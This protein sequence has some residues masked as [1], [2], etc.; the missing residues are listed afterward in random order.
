MASMVQGVALGLLEA[1]LV[2]G[3]RARLQPGSVILNLL[4][5][6]HPA[7]HNHSPLGLKRYHDTGFVGAMI[8][9][10]FGPYI[11]S[12]GDNTPLSV[13][14]YYIQ[15]GCESYYSTIGG[16]LGQI[17]NSLTTGIP[18]THLDVG[19]GVGRLIADSAS[20]GAS[21]GLGIDLFPL[22]LEYA[23]KVVSGTGTINLPVR[24][25]RC[26][27]KII[28]LRGLGYSTVFFGQADAHQLPVV[29]GSFTLVSCCNVLHRVSEPRLVLD[30][31][32]RVT[33]IGGFLLLSNSYDWDKE[34]TEINLWFDDILELH[35]AL[36][37]DANWSLQTRI[38]PVPYVSR[39]Y[40]RKYTLALNE[41]VLLRRES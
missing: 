18:V 36:G 21:L 20:Y 31:L 10:Q 23:Y 1:R 11:R 39:I 25:T 5:S 8:E 3:Y 38:D 22:P 30:E 13:S 2:S 27:E 40:D 15:S 26:R 35:R 19:T 24:S 34:Y 28:S 37:D 7:Y 4:P 12:S 6:G 33:S 16:I 14:N 32:R 17:L 41:I 29:D 9:R